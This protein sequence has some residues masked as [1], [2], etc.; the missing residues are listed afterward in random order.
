MTQEQAGPDK[1]EPMPSSLLNKQKEIEAGT[2]GASRITPSTGR[3]HE[4]QSRRTVLLNNVVL[5]KSSTW[6]TTDDYVCQVATKPLKRK[7]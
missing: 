3:S 5:K 2:T 4:T 7:M 6:V 1:R